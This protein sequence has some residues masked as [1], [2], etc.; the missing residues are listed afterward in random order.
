MSDPTR[1]DPPPDP[2]P[3]TAVAV[4]NADEPPA[5]DRP[6]DLGVG[7]LPPEAK[8]RLAVQR[9]NFKEDLA[10]QQQER[11]F[12]A[13][14]TKATWAKN[15]DPDALL[16]LAGWAK[17]RDLDLLLEFHILGGSAGYVNAKWYQ[18]Q[19]G[20]LVADGIV[21][22]A[23]YDV[24]NKDARLD[25]L[26]KGTG[27]EAEWAKG[28]ATRRMRERVAYGLPEEATAAVVWHVK[29][30]RMAREV[31]AAQA[32]GG[33]R[34]KTGEGKLK[35]PIAEEFPRE[36]AITRGVRKVMLSLAHVAP[37]L[38]EKRKRA[39]EAAEL[40]AEQYHPLVEANRAELRRLYGPKR[41]REASPE[42]YAGDLPSG[43]TT[44]IRSE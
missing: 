19:L 28:E 35:D 18:R 23:Y 8:A 44:D 36:T 14:S 2:Q 3:T 29:L 10:R 27:A 4:A 24:V 16:K 6:L 39:E 11:A 5:A 26:A 30:D 37:H 32:A 34:G 7:D 31:T 12:V 1:Q 13:A 22:Y 38:D 20:D 40:I 21:D 17:E 42:E 41:V 15:L 43:A 9:A 33:Y 25:T